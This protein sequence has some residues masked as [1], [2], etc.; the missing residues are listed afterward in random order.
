MGGG[1]TFNEAMSDHIS[2]CLIVGMA[3][4]AIPGRDVRRI[5]GNE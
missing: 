2:N 5:I 3:K 4:A 1:H